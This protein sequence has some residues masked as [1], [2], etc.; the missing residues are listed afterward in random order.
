M[1]A[2]WILLAIVTVFIHLFAKAQ[3]GN[4][5][6][7]G[8]IINYPNQLV[9][10]FIGE[11]PHNETECIM[12]TTRT[13]ANGY[14][15]FDNLPITDIIPVAL[16]SGPVLDISSAFVMEYT[17]ATVWMDAQTQAKVTV[18][19]DA[20]YLAKVESNLLV[21]DELMQIKESIRA[22]FR[23]FV[24]LSK[25]NDQIRNDSSTKAQERYKAIGVLL[26]E[27]DSIMRAIKK[28]FIKNHPKSLL[29]LY[30]LHNECRVTFD[31]DIPRLQTLEAIYNRVHPEM[32]NTKY[33]KDIKRR[34]ES[35]RASS[36][37]QMVAD[38]TCMDKDSVSFSL[39]DYR[40]KVVIMDFW[41]SWCY[42][43]REGH[44]SLNRLNNKYKAKGL[45]VLMF[46]CRDRPQRWLD[47]IEKDSLQKMRHVWVDFKEPKSV[48]D[49]YNI[50]SFPTRL[51]I[52]KKGKI[53]GRIIGTD[54]EQEKE[55]E[56]LLA[57][58]LE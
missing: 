6:L 52:D 54:E 56:K 41:G 40:G 58:N 37:G 10:I 12:H 45:E 36:V 15:S 57:A 31:Y 23:E 3:T 33:G 42:A 16:Q 29:S 5:K 4:A 27:K 34:V 50:T 38:F 13:D 49:L 24:A 43:C 2:K 9:R 44:P 32:R 8:Q 1:K 20:L 25:E 48:R 28:D 17:G 21:N 39:K 22:T 7:S 18:D 11:V 55:L 14:F 30:A 35:E 26:N 51:V 47:A 46:T 19:N 53:I